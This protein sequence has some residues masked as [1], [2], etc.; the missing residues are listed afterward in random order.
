MSVWR[1]SPSP[2]LGMP[3]AWV[4]ESAADLYGLE[5]GSTVELAL[6]CGDEM[7]HYGMISQRLAELPLYIDDTPAL[8]IAALRTR[9]PAGRSTVSLRP[10]SSGPGG[11]R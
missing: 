9:V 10:R 3:A 6:Q 4:S 7:K 1:V 5:P 2:T 11:S 8:S